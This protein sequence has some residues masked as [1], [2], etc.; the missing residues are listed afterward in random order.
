[1]TKR[2]RLVYDKLNKITS[3]NNGMSIVTVIVA[4]GFVA[5]LASIIMMSGVINFKMK[6]VNVYAKD[7]FYSAEQVLDEINVGLQ[8]M[9][10]DGLSYAYTDVLTKYNTE[11]L[12]AADKNNLV[13]ASYYEYIW[14]HL[15]PV[16]SSGEAI[17][18][19]DAN[20]K[21]VYYYIVQAR[22]PADN[23][24]V[25]G[26]DKVSVPLNQRG[27]Y[28]MLKESTKWHPSKEIDET[29]GAFLRSDVADGE[30]ITGND[31]YYLGALRT[32][33]NEGIVL[34]NLT[35]YYKDS[36]GFISA[37]KTDIRLGYPE[38]AFSDAEIPDIANYSF[39]TDTALV[40]SNTGV[41]KSAASLTTISGNT[42][43]YAVDV[44]GATMDNKAVEDDVDIHIVA[45][46]LSV[47]N[48]GFTTNGNS[49]LWAGDIVAKSSN[50]NL[51]G[52]SYVYDDLNIKGRDSNIT[53]KGYYTGFS[54]SLTASGESS[55]ILVNGVDT[56]LD[57]SN[58]RK[59]S[60][61]GRAYIGTSDSSGRVG[62]ISATSDEAD[63]DAADVYMGESIAVKSNQLMYLVP[64][65]CIGVAL[66][67]DGKPTTSMYGKNPLTLSEY[68]TI[69]GNIKDGTGYGYVEI[70]G[71]KPIAKLVGNLD[72]AEQ[73]TLEA[74]Q[75]GKFAKIDASGNPKV[76]KVF[77]KA[78]NGTDRLV[79]YY[80]TFADEEKA[81]EY[82]ARYYNMNKSAVDKYLN[83][84]LK[85]ITLPSYYTDTD[86][87]I[88]YT[89]K[90]D[91]TA[92][93]IGTD[94]DGA[95][96]IE[97]YLRVPD[98]G[99]TVTEDFETDKENYT[100]Q[101]QAYCSKLKSDYD[102]IADSANS[103]ILRTGFPEYDA[104]TKRM[105][106]AE[107][108]SA[109][110]Y[111]VSGVK[112]N[113]NYYTVFKNMVDEDI[114]KEIVGGHA[115]SVEIDGSEGK[116]LLIYD[117]DVNAV[118]SVGSG[119]RLV[120]ANCGVE[121]TGN[122]FEGCIIA[123][124]IIKLPTGNVTLKSAPDEVGSCL[125]YETEDQVYKVSDVFGDIEDTNFT[126]A[127]KGSGETVTTASLVTY[128][129][130]TKNV[131]IQ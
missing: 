85:A 106:V 32:Y 38:F 114:L 98:G 55:A 99:N 116:V 47:T 61:A 16:D 18:Y 4:I 22:N 122:T 129:K 28:G 90:F 57:L 97:S 49:V 128:E 77:L 19:K 78:A 53:L 64:G 30:S 29:Y 69:M 7:S 88:S 59:L 12:T 31:D 71:N 112:Y 14:K 3:D 105:K 17:P 43:A 39:I 103:D 70:A 63:A 1:M 96:E 108:D 101:Y 81:N 6:S 84:Y 51:A 72:T 94:S 79:Y 46:D 127:I 67:E 26:P 25:T 80:M 124:G 15:G 118:K 120:I 27:L 56:V 110:A 100:K 35:V 111:S 68:N 93:F 117:T 73:A 13:R 50:L 104:D 45:T 83:R 34:K 76:E 109:D 5:I 86:K 115:G 2:L 92:P 9:V 52:Q 44:T 58:I 119:Y 11:D 10:S 102:S 74:Y 126:K 130:W 123:K 113:D 48:G 75:L 95:H 89:L 33:E 65:D 40:Q 125:L 54:N 131:N 66:D 62:R 21:T 41:A 82:F 37:I 23:S 91:M 60:L 42:Y 87:A 121:L 8:Q 24:A 20:G 107:A 36:N